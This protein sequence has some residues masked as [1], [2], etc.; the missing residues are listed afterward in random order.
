[1]LSNA[2]WHRPPADHVNYTTSPPKYSSTEVQTRRNKPKHRGY[3]TAFAIPKCQWSQKQQQRF[4]DYAECKAFGNG[5]SSGHQTD[6][7]NPGRTVRPVCKTSD[8]IYRDCSEESPQVH[9]K[10]CGC[11]RQSNC[12]IS[13]SPGFQD[14]YERAPTA[15]TNPNHSST[16]LTN[17]KWTSESPVKFNARVWGCFPTCVYTAKK[18]ACN[19]ETSFSTRTEE[20]A[21]SNSTS[22]KRL[23]RNTCRR[24][25][26]SE[27]KSPCHQ[28]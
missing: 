25:T 24:I 5:A 23:D 2:T 4:T 22:Q 28:P 18:R 16:W 13:R 7:Q 27:R 1:M 8:S 20:S 9:A 15:Y 6:I 3:I 26:V 14:G 17:S 11:A 19:Y 10:S 12:F 21:T